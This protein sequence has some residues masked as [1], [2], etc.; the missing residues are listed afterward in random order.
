MKFICVKLN[1]GLGNQLFQ[2]AF[3]RALAKQSDKMLLDIS[4]YEIDYLGRQIGLNNLSVDVDI[5]RNKFV[6]KLFKSGTKLNRIVSAAGLF[7]IIKEEEFKLHNNLGG[8]RTFFT[9][10][11][12]YWQC[13][14]YFESIRPLLLKQF[15]PLQKPVLPN[16]LNSRLIA[17]HVRRTDYLTDNRY[18]FIGI[19]YYKQAMQFFRKKI[20]NPKFLFISDDLSWCKE[21]FKGEDLLFLDNPEWSVDYLQLYLMSQC[22][23]QIIANSSFSWWGAWLN[24]NP[25]KIIVRPLKPFQDS[26][27]LYENY[28]PKTWIA[29]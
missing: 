27:L 26:S 5:V 1:G 25:T 28:Y 18:G 16:F 29:F 8:K 23:H 22:N 6:Q 4:N 11:E 10:I 20:S 13:A 21:V 19:D 3:A 9:H 12:G 2:Y 7:S 15:V 14:D 24:T 17:V